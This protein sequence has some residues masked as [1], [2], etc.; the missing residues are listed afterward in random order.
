MRFENYIINEARGIRAQKIGKLFKFVGNKSINGDNKNYVLQKIED[1]N[2][3]QY[4]KYLDDL[5]GRMV[6]TTNSYNKSFKNAT[7]LFFTPESGSKNLVLIRFSQKISPIQNKDIGMK[8]LQSSESFGMKPQDFKIPH[9]TG[10]VNYLEHIRIMINTLFNKELLIKEYLHFLVNYVAKDKKAKL[11]IDV[12]NLPLGQ[13]GKNFG[14]ILGPIALFNDN[15]LFSVKFD[16]LKDFIVMPTAGNEKLLDYIIEKDGTNYN[17]SAK[18]KSGAAASLSSIYDIINKFPKEFVGFEKEI[19]ALNVIMKNS[20]IEAPVILCREWGL[21]DEEHWI[22][23]K[24]KKYD[25]PVWDNL[26]TKPPKAKDPE[27]FKDKPW[28]VLAIMAYMAAD[29]MNSPRFKFDD[30]I[31]KAMNS[32]SVIQINMY[33]SGKGVP[34]FKI[35]EDGRVDDVEVKVDAK[36]GYFATDRPKQR[37][38]FKIKARR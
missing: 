11:D 25:D 12:K 13:I 34:S 8:L 17:F 29:Y 21:I 22:A 10:Y 7:F 20:S 6:I 24:Q 33:L 28:W 2:I 27:K 36:K 14:E 30:L 19:E 37:I 4:E 9:R 3:K 32:V 31:I 23:W 18:Y 16:K 5:R 1:I 35:T 15:N 26:K 38:S